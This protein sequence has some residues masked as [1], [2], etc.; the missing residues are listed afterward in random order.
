VWGF[1]AYPNVGPFYCDTKWRVRE[2]SFDQMKTIFLVGEYQ[3]EDGE[4]QHAN[5]NPL[6]ELC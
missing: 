3:Y 6:E 2:K 1:K 5:K 4:H